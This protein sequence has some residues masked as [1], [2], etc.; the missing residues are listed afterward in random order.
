MDLL[1]DTER[2]LLTE[3]RTLRSEFNKKVLDLKLAM[4]QRVCLPDPPTALQLRQPFA[5]VDGLGKAHAAATARHQLAHRPAVAAALPS[6]HQRPG[7]PSNGAAPFVSGEGA[8]PALQSVAAA[9]SAAVASANGGWMPP[10][11]PRGRAVP[12]LPVH[13]GA[14]L[15]AQMQLQ[16]QR[17]PQQHGQRQHSQ[18]QQQQQYRQLLQ[19]QQAIQL[20][21]AAA[22]AAAGR[23]AR[24]SGDGDVI[25]GVV[26]RRR[27]G[28]R[29]C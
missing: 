3:L 19:L 4:P 24:A 16:P 13:V 14:L 1:L 15:P 2:Q 25:G 27:S 12:R 17:L 29:P 5:G 26:V 28:T 7:H 22:M 8:W 11:P 10:P 23:A 21:R 18:Q 20:Q 6:Q 9:A